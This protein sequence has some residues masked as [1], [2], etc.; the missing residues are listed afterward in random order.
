MTRVIPAV[1][2]TSGIIGGGG[3]VTLNQA[4]VFQLPFTITGGTT[5]NVQLLV[6][7]R[8]NGGVRTVNANVINGGTA[9]SIGNNSQSWDAWGTQFLTFPIA[10]AADTTLAA[11]DYIQLVLTN[12]SANGR[13]I[14]FRTVFGG[15]NAQIQMQSNTVVNID[16]VGV[17]SATYPA[18]TQFNSYAPG[19]TVFIRATVSDPFGNADIISAN[20]TITDPT[21]TVQVNN[22]A[23]TSVATPTG[24]TRVYEYQYTIPATPSGY[25]TAS[26]TA[27][28]GAEATVSHT[29]PVIMIVGNPGNL[30]L[31]SSQVISDPVNA[32]NP[33]A[34]PNAV[35]EYTITLTNTDFGYV[36]TDT[37][38]LT[39]PLP[40]S[41][42]L[43]LGSPADPVQFADGATSSGLTYTFTSLSSGTDD[44]DFSNDGGATFITPSVDGSGFDITAPL[45]N[46][47][48]INPKGSF[49]GSDGVNQPSFSI[50]FRA[51]VN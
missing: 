32:T 51:R 2:T 10:V 17:Y 44:I 34:I 13:D 45:I 26:I 22:A 27:N 18:T 43:F 1:D 25:W 16:S 8:S 37:L 4:I 49:R 15:N 48:R 31:K 23:M 24:A 40:S 28:E 50:Y 14:D 38:F 20:I 19:G 21:P 46:Y 47:I 41:L 3:T 9:V 35:I 33:K 6:R 36:D 39:D 5:I 11:G 29:T 30:L 12:T 42:T 7:R